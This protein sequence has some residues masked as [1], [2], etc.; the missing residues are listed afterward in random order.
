MANIDTPSGSLVLRGQS[1][2]VGSDIGHAFAVDCC[3][4]VEGLVSEEALKKKYQL[5][6]A[7][8]RQLELIEPLQL[9]VGRVKE[10]RIRDGTAQRE[11]ASLHWLSAVDVIH[12]II[13]DPATP[14]RSRIDG[15][16]ELR[17]CAGAGG[18]EANTPANERF[19]I[20]ISFGTHKVTKDVEL[21]PVA[22]EPLTIEGEDD[23]PTPRPTGI[24]TQTVR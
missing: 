4:F 9:L 10:E 16:R 23:L 17:A 22:R 5:D 6:D 7:G 12:G 2:E 19:I 11:K 1:I 18:A 21:K 20:N 13:Q 8:W 15:A 14:A 24:V 3:R